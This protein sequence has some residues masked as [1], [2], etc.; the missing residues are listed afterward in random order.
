MV[1][2]PLPKENNTKGN[3]GLWAEN[4]IQLAHIIPLPQYIPMS[5]KGF[6]LAEELFV[7]PLKPIHNPL[8]F[9]R[10][11]YEKDSIYGSLF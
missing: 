7:M 9:L 4:K 1:F 5:L 3:M 10:Y 2:D 8:S 11:K 6:L